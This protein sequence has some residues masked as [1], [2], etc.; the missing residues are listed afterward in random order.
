MAHDIIMIT[1]IVI[2]LAQ[3]GQIGVCDLKHLYKNPKKTKKNPKKPK[4]SQNGPG[5]WFW[6]WSVMVDVVHRCRPN[7][8]LSEQPSA[9][10]RHSPH[11]SSRPCQR[12]AP[13]MTPG[14]LYALLCS[15]GYAF[16]R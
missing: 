13:L 5:Y 2:F 8:R 4:R 3:S 16:S 11:C 12:W 14:D 10:G 7:H 9:E 6:F 15:L 1:F